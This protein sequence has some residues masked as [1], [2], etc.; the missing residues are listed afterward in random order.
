MMDHPFFMWTIIE[1]W[2]WLIHVPVLGFILLIA[3]GS[4]A[5]ANLIMVTKAAFKG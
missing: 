5:V 3:V 1:A 2:D 4:S